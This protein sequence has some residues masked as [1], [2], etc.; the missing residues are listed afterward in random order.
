MLSDKDAHWVSHV[1]HAAA[2]TDQLLYNKMPFQRTCGGPAGWTGSSS[3]ALLKVPATM[4]PCLFAA[5]FSTA[6]WQMNKDFAPCH[7]PQPAMSVLMILLS[8][9]H[10]FLCSAL[11][12]TFEHR[13]ALS[14]VQTRATGR[15]AAPAHLCQCLRGTA[16]IR[17]GKP[18]EV[19]PFQSSSV[20][21]GSCPYRGLRAEHG[22]GVRHANPP[23]ARCACCLQNSD[24]YCT[25]SA[26]AC[27]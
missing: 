14:Q 2:C 18:G 9:E 19:L 26:A 5:T 6:A 11:V 15:Q 13:S 21:S 25:L 8:P 1:Y 12:T 24:T 10:G 17:P 3:A 4:Q 20:L 23:G 22:F 27:R 7:L 16:E